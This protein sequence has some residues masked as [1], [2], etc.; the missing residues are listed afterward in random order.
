MF[1]DDEKILEER[2]KNRDPKEDGLKNQKVWKKKYK[3]EL[4]DF[5]YIHTL[6]EFS[7]LSPGGI[8]RPISL[9]T[10]ELQM[11]GI[12]IKVAKD[13]RNKWY[14][15]LG[16]F[17]NGKKGKGTFWRVYFDK[18]YFFYKYPD[19]LEIDDLKTEKGTYLLEQFVSK[20]ELGNYSESLKSNVVV[21]D[22]F[23][24]Y[25]KKKKK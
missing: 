15:L 8:I 24:E 22:L 6:E 3:V 17:Q 13:L 5:A 21:D 23:N 16:Y 20:E 9:N 10:E 11:G 2:L 18:N 7:L 25:I 1:K 19:K 4:L 14:A 12:L